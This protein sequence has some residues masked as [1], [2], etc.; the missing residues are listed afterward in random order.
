MSINRI[1][2]GLIA[3]IFSVFSLQ[4]SSKA[5]MTGKYPIRISKV[6]VSQ[7]FRRVREFLGFLPPAQGR[8]S[9]VTSTGRRDPICREI[10]NKNKP[11]KAIVPV[12]VEDS[13]N[14]SNTSENP[15]SV[16][17]VM[18]KTGSTHPVFWFYVPNMQGSVSE[19][20]F[21]LFEIDG[22]DNNVLGGRDYIS[23]PLSERDEIIGFQLPASINGV[24]LDGL[25]VNTEYRWVVRLVCDPNNHD[26]NPLISGWIKRVSFNGD[27]GPIVTSQDSISREELDAYAENGLW[28]E[29][30]T[31]L[32]SLMNGGTRSLDFTPEFNPESEWSR[33]LQDYAD[34]S[35]SAVYSLRHIRIV[36]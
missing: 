19:V 35:E 36:R 34:I 18:G 11:L 21:E 16:R 5:E 15:S 24:Q 26:K 13:E 23:I 3:S 22:D 8:H 20:Q 27:F 32:A 33:L 31:S 2:L 1:V 30:L 4:L 14:L 10:L 6:L 12:V 9:R 7:R 28:H 25:K 17:K 29:T